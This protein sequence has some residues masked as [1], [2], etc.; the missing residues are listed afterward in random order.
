MNFPEYS[1]AYILARYFSNSYNILITVKS[2]L[3]FLTFSKAYLPRPIRPI[4]K[5]EKR[6]MSE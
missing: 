3:E 4:T 5:A 2:Y 6:K 1:T